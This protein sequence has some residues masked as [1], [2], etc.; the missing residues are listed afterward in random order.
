MIEAAVIVMTVMGCGDQAV[1]C[2]P[3]AGPD[4]AW[5]NQEQCLAEIPAVL[6]KATVEPFP[7]L[8]ARCDAKGE[9]MA[10]GPADETVIATANLRIEP[11]VATPDHATVEA[12]L[13]KDRTIADGLFYRTRH[14][15]ALVRES[16]LSSWA[17]LRDGAKSG[18]N[19]VHNGVA[20][21]IDTTVGIVK[22]SAG[23]L[24]NFVRPDG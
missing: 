12:Q 18:Y 20:T 10:P 4:R 2:E 19:A 15:Y 14:G 6:H 21:S 11:A 3:I 13:N 9:L 17:L 7:V 5:Q 8:A 24:R 22:Y 1:Q 16:A 23:A